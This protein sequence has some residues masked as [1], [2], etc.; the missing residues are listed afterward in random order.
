MKK[1]KYLAFL[2]P[3]LGACDDKLEL[4]NPNRQTANEYWLT[5]DQA[6]G[7]VTAIYN[8]LILD[9]TY[10][11]M[12]PALTDGRGDD[13]RGDS[14]WGDLVQ[15]GNFTIPTTSGPVQWLWGAHYQL[16]FRANQ[17]LEKLPAIEMDEEL[18]NRLIGQAHFLR[19][20]AYFN[21]ANSFKA[22]PVITS[23]PKSTAE[24]Y[25][26]TA[27]EEV[28]WNQIFSDFQQAKQML[29]VSYSNVTG[30]DARQTGRATKGAATGML[31]KAYL[32]RKQWQQAATQFEE[33]M[34]APYNYRL[35]PEYR[36]N[37]KPGVAFEN[38]AESLFEVQFAT[39]DEVGGTVMNYGG[40]PSANWRQVSSQ[41]ST[42]AMDGKG[43]SDFL[44]TRG[45]YN[46]YKQEKT[47]DGKSD[48]RLLATI[49]SYEPQDNSVSAY[50]QPWPHALDALYPRK[51]THD[52]LGAANDNGE[53]SGINY[54]VLRY[55]DIL[56][57]HAEAL[58]ELG[59]TAEA[60]P[61]IQQ[62]RSRAN[63][64]DLATA[65]PNMTQQQM[66]DQIG[67]ER[68]LEFAIETQRIHDIIRWGWLYDPDKLAMLKAN[69]PDFNTWTPG[70][71]YLPIPQT[72]LDVN[73][74][75]LPNPAN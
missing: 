1:I 9:G 54:R 25:P 50:G 28:L 32:Y 12:Y 67:H 61:Y 6:V 33:L 38:N 19:G 44:P 47:V 43:Y 55:A 5:S 3:L 37:F 53:N 18:R 62:V 14:P 58:N 34:A 16:V 21:L 35:M 65:K 8:S 31:G 26:A 23:T 39:P 42:Y 4:T 13:L 73:K 2:L 66:R 49:A 74:N 17:A 72:E 52:G 22:V 56:L 60:Y 68:F 36:D 57:M 45:V 64:P 30:P 63:L 51:Y 41:A 48:P 75:L 20:L 11:R 46:E 70:N 10:M 71:E 24:Y 27:T 59:R 29:P 15:V 40:D 69:D 7:G